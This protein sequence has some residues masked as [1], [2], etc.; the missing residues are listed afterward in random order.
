MENINEKLTNTNAESID[1]VLF[2]CS[3]NTCRSPMAKYIM[4]HL[5]KQ[6]DLSEK[7]F[8]DSAGCNTYGGSPIS[9][10]ARA[11]L[12]KNKIPFDTHISKQFTV[13]EYRK[14]KCI[15]ALDEDMLL[16]AKEISGGDP[17]NK[18]RLFTDLDGRKIKVKDPFHADNPQKAYPI[19]YEQIYLGCSFLL[20]QLNI[21]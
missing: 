16:Q 19:A 7:I 8:V 13:Q 15:I 4:R 18:I 10:M 14:F 9:K 1:S 11:V 5:L 3:G 21:N 12:A 17:D 6:N 2:V 20:K